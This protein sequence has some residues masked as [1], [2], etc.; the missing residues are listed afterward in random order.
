MKQ[1]IQTMGERGIVIAVHR[2]TNGGDVLQNTS[3]AYQNALSHQADMVEVDVIRSKDGVFYGFHD[4]QEPLVFHQEVDIRQLTSQ[5]IDQMTCYNSVNEETEQTVERL[6]FILDQLR[7]KCL[8]NIDRSWFYWDTLLEELKKEE[9]LPQLLLKSPA[10]KKYLDQLAAS[11]LDIA[12]MPIVK[13]VD[14]LELA[15]SYSTIQIVAIELVFDSL[16]S[17]LLSPERIKE[18]HKQGLLLWA[19]P[20]CLGKGTQLTAGLDDNR[21]IRGD[22]DGSWGALIDM[23]FDILQTDWPLLLRHYIDN[24]SSR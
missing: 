6:S 3:L 20:I 16:D 18:L 5:E 9:T 19:N 2:G 4:G 1:T 15:L 13:N 23:G 10:E 24:R 14:E 22:Q 17:P 12:F 21:A 11:G 7:D 8:I